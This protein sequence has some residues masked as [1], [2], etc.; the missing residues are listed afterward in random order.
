M[1][2]EIKIYVAGKMTKHS[3]F[4]S[5]TWRDDFLKEINKLTGLEFISFDPTKGTKDYADPEMVFG[6]DLHMISQ[7]DVVVVYF[8]DDIG[9]GGSQEI[10]VAQ[11][12]NKP[13]IGLAPRGG[14]F[15][16]R[17][18]EVAGVVIKD[19]KHPFVFSTCDVVCGNIFELAEALKN[20]DKIK[21]RGINLIDK[22][23]K[24]FEKE[25]L[26]HKLYEL[27]FIK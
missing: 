15:N 18:R 1:N 20:L 23:K 3:H 16:G 17:D 7:V 5:H 13:V 21:P 25:H 19:Y 12:F 22:A 26:K 14:K 4:T 10:L 6:S 11:Y 2:K 24:R 9:V 27:H 8:S